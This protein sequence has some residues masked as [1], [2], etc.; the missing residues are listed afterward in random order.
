[1]DWL[2]VRYPWFYLANL[3]DEGGTLPP[4]ARRHW[5]LL[6]KG[7]KLVCCAG[8]GWAAGQPGN[9]RQEHLAQP[10]WVPGITGATLNDGQ[11]AL[12]LNPLTLAS[13]ATQLSPDTLLAAAPVTEQVIPTIM[14]VDDLLTVRKIVSRLLTREGYQEWGRC[15][16]AVAGNCAGNAG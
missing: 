14:V 11:I 15:A 10:A 5:I 8:G 12:I 7:A 13:R 9:R 2:D 4:P 6:L 1:M 16:G 3:L